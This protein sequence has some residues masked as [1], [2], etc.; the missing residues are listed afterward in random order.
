MWRHIDVQA[1]WRRSWTYGRAPNAID[2]SQGSLTCPSKHRHG[3]TLVIRWFRHI[4]PFSSLL[5]SR[6][7]YGGHILDLT[8]RALTGGYIMGRLELLFGKFQEALWSTRVSCLII[9]RVTAAHVKWHSEARQWSPYRLN[10]T[11][12]VWEQDKSLGLRYPTSPSKINFLRSFNTR[13]RHAFLIAI[14][15]LLLPTSS[16]TKNVCSNLTYSLSQDPH[17]VTVLIHS[18]CML[19]VAI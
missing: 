17:L 8:P 15:V 16:I 19:H 5:R 9:W 11:S 10:L 4:A 12:I 14:P 1:D 7:G 13:S 3:T 2:I 6:W 18:F